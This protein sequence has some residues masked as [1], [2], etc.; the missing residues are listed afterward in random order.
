MPEIAIALRGLQSS[1]LDNVR[2]AMQWLGGVAD[3]NTTNIA[4]G[5]PDRLTL[6]RE[7][8][9]VMAALVRMFKTVEGKVLMFF[10]DEESKRALVRSYAKRFLL[11]PAAH[12]QV[13][14]NAWAAQPGQ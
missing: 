14:R 7:F 2:L 12:L 9:D 5:L 10:I 3:V 8:A 11:E 13:M 4:N 6:S 1:N